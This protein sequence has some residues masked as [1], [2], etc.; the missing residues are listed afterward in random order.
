MTPPGELLV[1]ATSLGHA[2]GI[3]NQQAAALQSAS[4]RVSDMSLSRVEAG[5]FQIIIGP[6]DAVVAQVSARCAEGSHIMRD[7]A[8]ALELSAYKYEQ[9]EETTVATVRRVPAL[10]GMLP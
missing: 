8:S 6:Y 3:W 2:A 1:I 7:I 9:A 4:A 10:L 5:V